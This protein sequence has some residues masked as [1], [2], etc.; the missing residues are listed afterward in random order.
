MA[1]G[2]LS[3][4]TAPLQSSFDWQIS[5]WR[6]AQGCSTNCWVPGYLDPAG[7][8][9]SMQGLEWWSE[10]FSPGLQLQQRLEHWSLNLICC[11]SAHPSNVTGGRGRLI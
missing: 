4:R 3:A 7:L 6:A 1:D 5:R 10:V 9:H 2:E 11:I 8:G